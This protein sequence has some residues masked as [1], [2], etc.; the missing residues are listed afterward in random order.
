M[1]YSV[2]AV[3]RGNEVEI[4]IY[5]IISAFR[6]HSDFTDSV[7]YIHF[8]RK[9]LLSFEYLRTMEDI[10]FVCLFIFGWCF[11]H[12]IFPVKIILA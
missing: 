5:L 8:P 1:Y 4:F 9:L 10:L 11:W 6:G 12:I 2:S 7:S 3:G